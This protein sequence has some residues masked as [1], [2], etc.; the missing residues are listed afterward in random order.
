LAT[1][2][3]R[4]YVPGGETPENLRLAR[5][6]R[7]EFLRVLATDPASTEAVA[8][9][10]RIEFDESNFEEAE[11]WWVQLTK[12]QPMEREAYYTL[13]LIAWRRF[14]PVR[15]AVARESGA[16]E[17]V[18]TIADATTRA[19]LRR[20]WLGVIDRGIDNLSSAIAIDP[21]AADALMLMA[22]L[23]R[24]RAELAATADDYDAGVRLADEW[25]QK[26]ADVRRA[27]VV[28][29]AASSTR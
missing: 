6:A 18:G 3:Y 21:G 29:G 5:S 4:Q 26:A 10:A 25:L 7:S 12:M 8:G 9:L 19:A 27:E 22:R 1:T 17:D 24:G 28:T 11:K 16:V 2:Y 14:L 15:M 20:D 23:V 13:G